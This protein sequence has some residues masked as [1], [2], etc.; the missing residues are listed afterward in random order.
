MVRY[1]F[2][3]SGLFSFSILFSSAWP[4]GA[5]VS[6]EWS[7]LEKQRSSQVR[8]LEI[9]S[10]PSVFV[11]TVFFFAFDGFSGEPAAFF[12]FGLAY[13]LVAARE[14][15]CFPSGATCFLTPA[16]NCA[17]FLERS[18][19][20]WTAWSLAQELQPFCRL[21]HRFEVFTCRLLRPLLRM[22]C[23]FAP[24]EEP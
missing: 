12:P 4:L 16:G 5:P 19:V 23:L 21:R 15:T 13:L 18:M 24:G 20:T 2:S 14:P 8:H 1:L 17:V 22:R 11:S 6:S 3:K 7:G 10:S 9:F